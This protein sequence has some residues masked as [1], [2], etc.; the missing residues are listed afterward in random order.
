MRPD[1]ARERKMGFDGVIGSLQVG[2]PTSQRLNMVAHM[3]IAVL[4]LSALDISS[5]PD[6]KVIDILRA[7]VAEIGSPRIALGEEAQ[8]MA[9]VSDQMVNGMGGSICGNE[10]L[11][12]LFDEQTPIGWNSG[13]PDMVVTRM[14]RISQPWDIVSIPTVFRKLCLKWRR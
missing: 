3:R 11:R 9:K 10:I 5:D 2:E 13:E 7:Q 8:K 14:G 1:Q 6:S 12:I 4:E